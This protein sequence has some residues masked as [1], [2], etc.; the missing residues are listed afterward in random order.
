[1]KEEV[2]RGLTSPQKYLPSKFFYDSVGSALFE[3]ICGLPEYYQTRTE[4]SL[5]AQAAPSIM[6]NF[7]KGNLVE[8]GAGSNIKIRRLLDAGRERHSDITYVP[9]DVSESALRQNSTELLDDYSGLNVCCVIGDFTKQFEAVPLNNANLVTFFGSTIGNFSEHEGTALLKN[10]GT[11]LKKGDRLLV[12]M[13]MVKPKEVLE[14][15]YNDAQ[16]ITAAFNKNILVV[17]NR[18]LNA[19]FNLSCFDHVAF[20]RD[21]HERIEMHLRANRDV[22]ITL[23]DI[24]LSISMKKGET[25]FTEISRKYNNGSIHEMATEAGFMIGRCF[26]DPQKW[27]SLVEMRL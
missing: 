14:A 20:Y 8:L 5:L 17:L 1:M 9:V 2:R 19:N 26:T 3:R 4:L 6:G 13:D 27:F 16:G 24:D 25:I 23:R 12:G 22:S 7:K 15:A 18:E 10:I 11:K 21:E